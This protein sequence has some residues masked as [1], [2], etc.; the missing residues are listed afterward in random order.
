MFE[1]P[2]V[3]ETTEKPPVGGRVVS[4]TRMEP[5]DSGTH[6]HWR[7]DYALPGGFVGR[8]IDRL[9]LGAAFERTVRQYNENF[10]ALAEGRTPP[11]VSRMPG[12]DVQEADHV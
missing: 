5:E 10:K 8:A 7:M 11:H 4:M 6:V 2:H 1:P 9:F 3:I 12:R